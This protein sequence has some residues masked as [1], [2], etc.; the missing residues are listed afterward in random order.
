MLYTGGTTG[1]PKGVMYPWPSRNSFG[2][3]CRW[4]GANP[5]ENGGL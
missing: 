4:P 3:G 5:A 2:N 1:L